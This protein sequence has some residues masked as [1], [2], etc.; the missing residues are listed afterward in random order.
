M[1]MASSKI[2]IR[3]P[4]KIQL[5]VVKA[6]TRLT[7]PSANKTRYDEAFSDRSAAK[8]AATP[9]K[10]IHRHGDEESHQIGLDRAMRGFGL[11]WILRRCT[12]PMTPASVSFPGVCGSS[13]PGALG[14][15][16]ER[17]SH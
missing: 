6:N 9:L 13:T 7:E 4:T 12:R 14:M 17:R 1:I 16:R 3:T 10:P 2:T 5:A 15:P 11:R 8:S